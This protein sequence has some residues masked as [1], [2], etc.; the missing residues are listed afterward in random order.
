MKTFGQPDGYGLLVML[1]TLLL[2][3]IELGRGR[4]AF[5][6]KDY[7]YEIVVTRKLHRKLRGDTIHFVWVEEESK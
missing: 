7:A 2:K 5:I 4:G 3:A 1:R 6:T